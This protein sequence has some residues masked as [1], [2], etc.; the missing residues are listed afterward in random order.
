MKNKKALLLIFPIIT[1]ILEALPY[2]AV[3]N[4]AVPDG[5]S[6]RKTFSYFSLTPYGYA[7]FAPFITAIITCL[8]FALLVLYCV[9]DKKP[10]FTATKYLL[11]VG[12]V[13]SLC[14]LTLGISSFS[15]V[16]GL[17]SMSL[18][19]ELVLVFYLNKQK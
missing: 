7:N 11:C 10:L 4:F 14:P 13:L 19:A 3:L 8:I 2:G 18:L 17:I 9:T 12:T 5:E 1:L 16:G 15:V 6:A